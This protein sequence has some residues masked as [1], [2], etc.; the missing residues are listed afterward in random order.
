MPAKKSRQSK[1]SKPTRKPPTIWSVIGILLILGLGYLIKEGYID[2]NDLPI[3]VEQLGIEGDQAPPTH[4]MPQ[5]STGAIQ[6]YF[7]TP[8]L[9]YPDKREQRTPPPFEQQLLADIDNAQSSVDIAAFEYNLESIAEALVRAKERGVTVRLALDR[10]NLEDPEEAAWAGTVE[11]VG[12]PI[13]WQETTAFLHS[14]FAIIDETIVWMGSWNFT[15]NGTYRNNNN[16]LRFTIPAIVENYSTEFSQMFDDGLFG[17]NKEPITPNQMIQVDGIQI[18]NY[19]SPQDRADVYI[20]ERLEQAEESIRFMAFSYTSDPIGEAMVAQHNAGVEV[21]GVF[22]ARSAYGIGAEFER[23]QDAGIEVHQDGNCYTMHHKVIIIDDETVITG[24]YNFTKRAL[25]TN[26]ENFVIIDDPAL[27][28]M[29][30]EEYNRVY[31]Q[32]IH[33]TECGR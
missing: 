2:P 16:L 9:V 25:D 8:Y 13:S 29:Y 14:K 3:D 17:N 22:E 21:Q 10:E 7:T 20:V 18:A 26:D 32:A 33:P 23:L 30:V 5:Q 19:F 24:S 27:A 28:S 31:D 1:R 11:E 15:N 6:P 12:I 4:S